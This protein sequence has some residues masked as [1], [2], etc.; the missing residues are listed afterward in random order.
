MTRTKT[1]ATLCLL[2]LAAVAPMALAQDRGI[3]ITPTVGY[4]FGGTVSTFDNAIISSVEVPD[5]ISFGITAE[6]PVHPNLNLEVLWSHQDTTLEANFNGNPPA[7]KNAEFSHLN[8]DTLQI[9]GLWQSGRRGDKIRGYFDF[10]LG[11]SILNPSPE[12]QSLTRFSMTIGG[13]A[14]FQLSDK[15][16]LRLGLR[17]MPVYINSE[18]SGYGYCDPYWGCYEYYDSNY[19]YQ[20]DAHVGLIIKF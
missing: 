17:W 13:G 3:E 14:K 10:L 11:A 12:Y 15:I 8:V 5:T 16:G 6:W 2:A 4:R 18:G 7:G 20:T 9:G 1:L 19:L